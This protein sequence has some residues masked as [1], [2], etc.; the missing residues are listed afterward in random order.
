[1]MMTMMTLKKKTRN[2]QTNLSFT[3]LLNN[4]NNSNHSY[5]PPHARPLLLCVDEIVDGPVELGTPTQAQALED[6]IPKLLGGLF[7]GHAQAQRHA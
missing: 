7:L 3:K 5:H 4:N 1:M 2:D 6:E